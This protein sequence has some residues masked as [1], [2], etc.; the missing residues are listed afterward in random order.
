M[1]DVLS[2]KVFTQPSCQAQNMEWAGLH[3]GQ[4]PSYQNKVRRN[5]KICHLESTHQIWYI[6]F[7]LNP[8]FCRPLLHCSHLRNQN[9]QAGALPDQIAKVFKIYSEK[10]GT[11]SQGILHMK[12]ALFGPKITITAETAF[13]RLVGAK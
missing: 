8:R 13:H 7:V 12:P 3:C 10:K 5:E 6:S 9:K 1:D 2:L 11:T 4:H